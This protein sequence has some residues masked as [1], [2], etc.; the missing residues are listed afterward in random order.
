M[1]TVVAPTAQPPATPVAPRPAAFPRWWWRRLEL[2]ANT[3]RSFAHRAPL[4]RGWLH[5]A[6]AVVWPIVALRLAVLAPAGEAT[7][8]AAAFGIGMQ[9][10]FTASAV[11]HLRRWPVWTTEVLFRFDH[12]GIFMAIGGSTTPVALLALD[13]WQ[14][15]VVLSLAWVAAIAGIVVVLH[16]RSTP[17]G[18][19]LS[20]YLGAGALVVPFLPTIY[21]NVGTGG[22]VLLATGAITYA[23]GG[24]LLSLQRPRTGS[25][26]FGYHEVWHA[27]VV[28]GVLQH[29]IMIERWLLPLG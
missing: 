20:A 8:G 19:A 17:H 21:A 9:V 13:G 12:M 23:L 29:L 26:I 6:M 18:F 1:D 28:A 27:L 7:W 2:S 22:F 5:L 3:H 24:V 16:P 14:S 11:T 4:T 10:M 15:W 25:R